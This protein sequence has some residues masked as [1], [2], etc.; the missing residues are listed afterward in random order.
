MKATTARKST[1]QRL[2]QGVAE[3]LQFYTQMLEYIATHHN[4]PLTVKDIAEHIGLR[5]RRN[6]HF[7]TNDADVTIKQ[8]ITAMRINHA[9][10]TSSDTDRTILRYLTHGFH[11]SSRFYETFQTYI[12]ATPTQYRCSSREDHRWSS[13]GASPRLRP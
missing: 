12:G 3:T 1:G 5:Q 2:L 11:P 7:V 8:Y 4:Q 9:R 13:H 10:A 6:I